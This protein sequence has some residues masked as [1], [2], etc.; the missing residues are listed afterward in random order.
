MAD[1][2]SVFPPQKL[3]LR[4]KTKE[5]KETSLEG[6]ISRFSSSGVRRS[7]ME[8]AYNMMNSE[9][10]LSDLK[11][12]TDPYKVSEGFP[13]KMQNVNIVRPKIEL[14][15]GEETKRP[16]S[17]IVFRTDESAVDTIVE[18]Q[19]SMIYKALEDAIMNG[20]DVNSEEIMA[21]LQQRMARIKEYID[22]EYYD[23]AEQTAIKTLKYLK[24]KLNL[25]DEF[26]IGWED[27]L[28][29]GEEV[30]YTGVINGEPVLERVNPM[31]MEYDP[32]PN[33]RNIDEGDWAVRHMQMTP[34]AVYDRFYDKMEETQ[35]DALLETIQ[36]GSTSSGGQLAPNINTEY[37]LFRNF[38]DLSYTRDRFVDIYHAVWKSFKKIGYLNYTDE[39]GEEQT[40]LVDETYKTQE[41]EKIVWDWILEWWEGYRIGEDLYIGIQPIEY[42]NHSIDNPNAQAGPYT[43]GIYNNNNA[44]RKSLVEIMKPLQY[45]YLVL[46][47]RLELTLAR[48]KGKI[49]MMDIT[50][51]PKGIAGIDENKFMHYLSSM[52][53]GFF[54]PYDEGWNVPGREGGKPA[55]FNQFTAIDLSMG[56]VIAEYIQ[57]LE[58]VE[59]M[60]G[61][62]SGIS[63]AR[64]GQ[65][66][67][68]EL[69]GNVEREVV[70]SSHITEPLFWRHN[71]IKRRALTNLLNAAKYAWKM[72]DKKKLN[73]IL[74]GPERIFLEVNE[75][76]LYSDHDVFITDST[77]EHQNIEA[78]KTLYQPAMQN[79]ATLLDI[80]NIM[81]EDSVSDIKIKLAEVEKKKAELQQ[82]MMQQEQMMAQQESQL[83]AEELRI[84]EEDSI[85]KAQTA[86]DVALIQAESSNNNVTI[87]EPEDNSLEIEKVNIQKE[88]L[89]KDYEI[90]LR[91]QREVER[92]NKAAET[93]SRIKKPTSNK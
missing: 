75:D 63:R 78:L 59:T 87:E 28:I 29:A 22:K 26:L 84:K 90:N 69:V 14:L 57:L 43:G 45:M 42:Q 50:Q 3:P 21:Q 66:H 12:V 58:K 38:E 23:P 86:L 60:V 56:N 81:T 36:Q 19:K 13:A 83:K 30:Y 74:N 11:Y 6:I 67:R 68:S 71:Q 70:Q 7:N 54:N 73:F 52:G 35:L 46:W 5:W 92:H 80:A 1:K 48:D 82:Q 49:L 33:L 55:S 89:G 18:K 47:Y 77:Q 17:L 40:E 93:I 76:F 51:I 27:A 61:E 34:S 91:K 62:L 10:D 15:K 16:D 8:I 4:K 72:N 65:I 2:N 64:Q 9:F 41:G 79:G 20:A 53:V 25:K 39:Y 88:K 24:E 32:D 44:T 37:I 85:R 31:E